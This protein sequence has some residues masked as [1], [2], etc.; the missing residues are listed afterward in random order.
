MEQVKQTL[1]GIFIGIGIY[2]LVIEL[3]GV[4]FSGDLMAYTLGLLIGTAVATFLIFHMTKTLNRALDLP[5]VQATKYVRKQTFLRLFF[6]IVAMSIGLI[7]ER[8]NF[9]ALVLGLLGVKIGALLAPY[10][11]KKM[12]PEFYVTQE[13]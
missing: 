12:Y 6:M 13:E 4:F 9:I 10:F 3:V 7:C 8:V 5:E 1:K 2:A 11:L